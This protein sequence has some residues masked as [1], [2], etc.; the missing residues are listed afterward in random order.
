MTETKSILQRYPKAAPLLGLLVAV[1]VLGGALLL[2]DRL[3]GLSSSAGCY[4]YNC[5]PAVYLKGR[6]V[7]S[8]NP[9]SFGTLTVPSGSYI[10]MAW[11]AVSVDRCTAVGGWTNFQGLNYPLTQFGQPITQNRRF[12]VKCFRGRNQVATSELNVRVQATQGASLTVG[13][14]P[15]FGDQEYVANGT[16]FQLAQYVMSAAGANVGIGINRLTFALHTNMTPKQIG[17]VYLSF[18][19]GPQIRGTASQSNGVIYYDFAV[20]QAIPNGS[21]ANLVLT[22]APGTGSIGTMQFEL[23]GVYADQT[24]NISGLPTFG[25]MINFTAFNCVTEPCDVK[26]E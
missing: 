6:V 22:S 14:T 20:G 5:T 26:A 12:V 25:Q 1:V 8:G 3:S 16:T 7:G 10:E 24:V 13:R 4:G 11:D 23:T 18:A 15:G 21:T 19:V 17:S 2:R 9:L